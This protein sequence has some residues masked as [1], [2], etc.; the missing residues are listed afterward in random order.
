MSRRA[1]QVSVLNA[2]F[3]ADA[4]VARGVARDELLRASRISAHD[5][6]DDR[7]RIP[8]ERV[9]ALWNAAAHL[10]GDAAFGLHLA[11]RLAPKDFGP[12]GLAVRSCPT[13]QEA[14]ERLLGYVRVAF[15]DTEITLLR[16]GATARFCH[17]YLGDAALATRHAADL[18]LAMF[19]VA[20]RRFIGV[21]W[22]P[23]AVTFKFPAPAAV[24]EYYRV[25]GGPLR[26]DQPIN[27]VVFEA[28]LLDMPMA[29]GDPEVLAVIDPY[30]EQF[31]QT[32]SRDRSLAEAVQRVIAAALPGGDLELGASARALGL[33]PRTLQRRLRD[34][35]TS[36]RQ[37]LDRVRHERALRL[38]RR[39]ELTVDQIADHLGFS[40][41]SAFHRAFRRWTGRTP[42][43]QRR[44]GTSPR[45]AP[46][47]APRGPGALA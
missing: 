43:D 35:G 1:D 28:A 22:K 30:A 16:E 24:D 11:E 44:R 33:S 47:E 29:Q 20:G 9:S 8:Y 34:E 37:I 19:V 39:D 32:L 2:R 4:A 38:L 12:L 26:F 23:L 17:H 5:L 7:K 21:D 36:H 45:N 13:A 14:L 46:A 18:I 42:T 3:I 25:F 41:P 27:S 40:E 6:A 15:Q 31:L 10:G